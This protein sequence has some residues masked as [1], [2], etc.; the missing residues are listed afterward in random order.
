MLRCWHRLD[1]AGRGA[2]KRRRGR[3]GRWVGWTHICRAAIKRGGRPA[4]TLLAQLC[5][6]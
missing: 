2:A 6:N 5:A 4:R 3:C 1:G